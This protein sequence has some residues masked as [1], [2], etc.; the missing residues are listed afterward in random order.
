M[1]PSRTLSALL[2]TPNEKDTE[3]QVISW[4]QSPIGYHPS[5][6]KTTPTR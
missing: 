4:V 6:L 1:R 2:P 3:S 5:V